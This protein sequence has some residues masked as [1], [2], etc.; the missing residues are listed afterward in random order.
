M[1]KD[2]GN[3]LF[4]W[5][6]DL[7]SHGFLARFTVLGISSLLL[8]WTLGPI[9]QL[10]VATFHLPSSKHLCQLVTFLEHLITTS[11]NDLFL[12][13]NLLCLFQVKHSN[14]EFYITDLQISK[15]KH[16]AL[17]FLHLSHPTQYIFQLYPFIWKVHFSLQLNRNPLFICPIFHYPLIS[18]WRSRLLPFPGYC[19]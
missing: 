12:L 9:R 6:D 7:S 1:P 14:L 3:F 15:K 13:S 8:R 5:P 17:V 18:W 2:V 19:E 10:F 16:V 4:K 11:P